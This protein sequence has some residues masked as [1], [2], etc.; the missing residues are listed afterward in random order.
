MDRDTLATLRRMLRPITLRGAL[1]LERAS[2][3]ASLNVEISRFHAAVLA[4]ERMV[5][6]AGRLDPGL[7]RELLD[8]AR[9]L[10]ALR[11]GMEQS[12][13]A[14]AATTAERASAIDT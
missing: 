10:M 2:S 6:V 8:R 3:L 13:A 14:R 11:E 7:E 12:R 1:T 5:K 9:Q 4:A